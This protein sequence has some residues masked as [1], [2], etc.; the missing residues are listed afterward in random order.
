MGKQINAIQAPPGLEPVP[1][2][3]S[4][5]ISVDMPSELYESLQKQEKIFNELEF[6]KEKM[7]VKEME[8]EIFYNQI[9]KDQVDKQSLKIF[10]Y[11]DS[12]IS[13][14][15]GSEV[16]FS[17]NTPGHYSPNLNQEL[18]DIPYLQ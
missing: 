16:S 18:K 17:D 8:K 14:T 4:Y 9:D 10:C 13:T 3:R 11:D 5:N 2:R 12:E 7:P 6:N 1:R 15:R